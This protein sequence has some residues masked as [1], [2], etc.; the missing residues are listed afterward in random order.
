MTVPNWGKITPTQ[1]DMLMVAGHVLHP[2]F[3]DAGTIDSDEDRLEA[4]RTGRERLRR[5]T[6][7]DF[8]YDLSGWHELLLNSD[9]DQWGYRHPYAWGRVGPAI[10]RA[11]ADADRIRLAQL[12]EQAG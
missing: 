12:L 1:G 8:G 4:M 11:I 7:Q 9:D 5:R 2:H 6:G 3:V 10:E